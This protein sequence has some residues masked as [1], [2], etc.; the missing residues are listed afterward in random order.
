MIRLHYDIPVGNYKNINKYYQNSYRTDITTYP[1]NTQPYKYRYLYKIDYDAKATVIIGLGFN[2]DSK[3]DIYK[4]FIEHNP[5]KVIGNPQYVVD[6]NNLITC[7]N[8][9]IVKRWDMAID[10][11]YPRK[12]VITVKD[13]RHYELHQA[14]A[15]DY[16]EYL[17]ARNT[18]GRIKVYNKQ[19]EQG[20]DYPLT[21]IELTCDGSWD[22]PAIMDHLPEIYITQGTHNADIDDLSQTQQ[23]LVQ[24]L[25]TSYR[26]DVLYRQLDWYTKAKIKPYLFAT[27]TRLQYDLDAI[28]AIYNNIIQSYIITEDTKR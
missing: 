10:I 13:N 20:L 22:A 19:A 5:N 7:V 26:R 17:G 2:G 15:D 6:Y 21:R 14:S 12:N 9:P 23:V 28:Y 24:A 8:K 1:V 3:A 11:P 25:H 16:T 4:G 18:P 27:E